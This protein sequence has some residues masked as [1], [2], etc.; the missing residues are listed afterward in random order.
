MGHGTGKRRSGETVKRG[1]EKA[2]RRGEVIFVH[3]QQRDGTATAT[4][5]ALK[6]V[7]DADEFIV[8][9]GDVVLTQ[10]M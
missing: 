5:L 10:K 3:Q 1:S 2:E 7:T 9:Y 8:A 4:L 6:E